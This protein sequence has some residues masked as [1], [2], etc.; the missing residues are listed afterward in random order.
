MYYIVPANIQSTMQGNNDYFSYYINRGYDA[1]RAGTKDRHKCVLYII[2][3]N[4]MI[5]PNY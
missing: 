5:W 2:D 1:H 4:S 3:E